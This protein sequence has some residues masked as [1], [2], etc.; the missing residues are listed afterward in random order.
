MRSQNKADY[1]SFELAGSHADLG[2]L[3]GR[4][5]EPFTMQSWWAK[6]AELHFT[7]E[8]A[9]VIH[10]LHA[11]LIDEVAAYADAQDL[12]F[13]AL[14]RC[15]CRV[16]LMAR[17]R[18]GVTGAEG[19]SSF[20]YRRGE[21]MVVGRNYDYWPLQTRRQRIRFCPVIDSG[22]HRAFSSM[23]ARGSVPCGRY[24]GMNEFGVFVSLH[25]V[26]T[27]TTP[28]HEAQPGVPFHL[29][30]RMVLEMSNSAE[31]A[32]DLLLRLPHLSALNYL[33]AD[34]H[35]AFV[36]E[37]APGRARVRPQ[38]HT[39]FVAA[40]NHFEHPDMR[41][42]MGR[43]TSVNSECRLKFLLE[44][45]F[46]EDHTVNLLLDHAERIMADRSVPICGHS[47]ALTTLW[48]W[49]AELG[50]RRL[51]F[52]AGAPGEVG[53]EEFSMAPAIIMPLPA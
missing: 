25:V 10:D 17:L 16:D 23:G 24:D 12:T 42:L 47:G 40:T 3:L 13:D 33:V 30:P 36:I 11:P 52:C 6:P 2:T 20:A 21:S 49:V 35:E 53:F 4:A 41:V 28:E 14:W 1:R 48:S 37:A 31:S 27:N 5:D 39:H 51:R 15:C 8:C 7:R 38:T 34:A 26:M 43:R 46:S 9:R 22:N 29:V 45:V 44:P 19:C 50:S 18:A 32:K